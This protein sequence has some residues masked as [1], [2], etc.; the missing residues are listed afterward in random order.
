MT[1][2]ALALA[3]TAEIVK[4]PAIV[5]IFVAGMRHSHVCD[6]TRSCV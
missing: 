6:T 5:G 2:F 4:V 1:A 3:V